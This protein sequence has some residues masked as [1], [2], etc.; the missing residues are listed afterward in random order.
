MARFVLWGS[1]LE[2]EFH[3]LRQHPDAG[4][5]FMEPETELAGCSLNKIRQGVAYGVRGPSI[6]HLTAVAKM[7]NSLPPP[8]L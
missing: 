1:L 3:C 5:M 8:G 7:S 2:H 4:L 6:C